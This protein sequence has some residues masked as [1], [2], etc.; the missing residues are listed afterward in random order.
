MNVLLTVLSI[1][2]LL[3]LVLLFCC[4]RKKVIPKCCGCFQKLYFAIESRI[5]FNS[6]LR[7]CLQTFFAMSISV[8]YSYSTLSTG[9]S[10]EKTNV[11]VAVLLTA[12]LVVSPYISFI[13]LKRHQVSLPKK[14]CKARFDSLY[15][16]VDYY[17]RP[18]AYLYTM[19]FLLRRVFYACV[20]CFLTQA[21]VLQVACLN[22]LNLCVLTFF[23]GYKP[24]WDGL[25]NGVHIFNES[26]VVILTVGMLL[27]TDFIGDP[28]ERYTYGYWFLYVAAFTS[29]ANLLVFLWVI[30]SSI[31][32]AIHRAY[33]KRKAKQGQKPTEKQVDQIRKHQKAA[34][35]SSSSHVNSSSGVDSSS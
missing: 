31:Y 13:C 30:L 35:P 32:K 24:M 22:I 21:V 26:A 6:I 28:E 15:S 12:Y 14:T 3:L 1:I 23:I 34:D 29:C 19:Q 25:N 27:F 2:G 4:C 20:I 9:T 17:K 16:K 11:A 8:C 5:F 7:A 18:S 33:K 10:E